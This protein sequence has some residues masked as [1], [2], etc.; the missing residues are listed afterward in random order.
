MKI[1]V[2][3]PLGPRVIEHATGTAELMYTPCGA[4]DRELRAFAEAVLGP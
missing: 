3:M 1:S 4:I 2:A